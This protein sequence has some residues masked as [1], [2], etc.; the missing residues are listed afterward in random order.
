MQPILPRLL[1]AQYRCE[2]RN[3]FDFIIE[4]ELGRA[5]ESETAYRTIRCRSEVLV[6]LSITFQVVAVEF[7]D[8]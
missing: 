4:I 7:V 6:M 3:M 5:D 2:A 8:R 1:N